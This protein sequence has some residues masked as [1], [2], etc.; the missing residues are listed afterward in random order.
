MLPSKTIVS[1][2]SSTLSSFTTN[3]NTALP[4]EPEA[5]VI[6]VSYPGGV[7][8]GLDGRVTR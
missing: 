2:G 3:V 5:M 4:V 7:S 8:E 6:P 1:A